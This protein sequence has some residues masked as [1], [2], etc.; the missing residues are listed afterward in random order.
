MMIA[1]DALHPTC[2]FG[3][4]DLIVCTAKRPYMKQSKQS[5][6]IFHVLFLDLGQS[7]SSSTH[8]LQTGGQECSSARESTATTTKV[9][10]WSARFAKMSA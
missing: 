9:H 4:V 5:K 3:N 10:S 8:A 6:A 7:A 2:E 1:Q